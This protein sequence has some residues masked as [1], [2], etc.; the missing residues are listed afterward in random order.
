VKNG[1]SARDFAVK[2]LLPWNAHDTQA[3]LSELP[4]DFQ[5]QFT[6]GTGPHG[7]LYSGKAQ[8]RDAVERLFDTVPDIHYQIV[9]LHEGPNLLVMELL[10]TGNN[11]ETGANL[12]FQACDIVLFDGDQLREKRS[13]RKVVT[14]G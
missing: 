11:R 14:Q 7:A 8:I 5:W 12:N 6:T 2:F 13:Y 4:D 9:D 10:V 1:L 3:V